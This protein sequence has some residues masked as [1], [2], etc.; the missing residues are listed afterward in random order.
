[1]LHTPKDIQT[2]RRMV[3]D[4]QACAQQPALRAWAWNVLTG[5]PVAGHDQPSETRLT[6]TER[7]SQTEPARL[8]RIRAHA[9]RLQVL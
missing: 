7:L 8:A 3:A 4:P 5:C 9:S 1:M 2:A 6:L